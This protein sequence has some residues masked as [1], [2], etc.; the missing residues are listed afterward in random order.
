MEFQLRKKLILPLSVSLFVSLAGFGLVFYW[1]AGI[2]DTTL[3]EDLS[4]EDGF[5]EILGALGFLCVS[6]LQLRLFFASDLPKERRLIPFFHRNVFVLGLAVVFFFAFGEEISWGQRVFGWQTPE[7][8]LETNQQQET[9]IHNLVFF[10][11]DSILNMSRMFNLFWLGYCVVLPILCCISK[12]VNGI[13]DRVSLPVPP[14]WIAGLFIGCYCAFRIYVGF[15]GTDTLGT[16]NELK[17]SFLA[18]CFLI[19]SATQTVPERH[20]RVERVRLD[21]R[22]AQAKSVSQ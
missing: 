6:L 13:S 16:A 2:A 3:A 1:F 9:N 11:G 12:G 17:E 10:H 15:V 18:L 22:T 14:V 21:L 20:P 7:S 19:L 8:L 4:S 5:F